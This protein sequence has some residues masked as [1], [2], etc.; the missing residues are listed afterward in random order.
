MKAYCSDEPCHYGRPVERL[1]ADPIVCRDVD[2][3]HGDGFVEVCVM[4][5][6]LLPEI[7]KRLTVLALQGQT[8]HIPKSARRNMGGR[9][10]VQLAFTF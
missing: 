6:Q 8:F 5:P 2:V 10:N 7:E 3:I 1:D 9:P 4:R